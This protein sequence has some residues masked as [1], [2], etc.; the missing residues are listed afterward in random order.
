MAIEIGA[1]RA[2][3][4]LNSAAFEKGARRAEASMSGL[5]RSLQRASRRFAQIGRTM[6]TR[7]TL[8]LVGLGSVALKSSL[9]VVD[10]Q[11][12]MAQSLGTS[13]RSIQVLARAADRAGVSTGEL[14]QIALQLTKR[15]SQ[16]AGGTGP[17]VKALDRLGLS[18]DELIK[19]DLDQ[20][21]GTINAAI[22]ETVPAAEQAAVSAKLFGD[23]AGVLASLLDAS[24]IKAA[25]D[26]IERFGVA[27]TEVEADQIE[28]A[29]DAISALG[30]VTRGLA[31][32]LAVALAPSLQKL[33][34]FLADVAERFSGLPSEMQSVIGVATALGVALGPISIAIGAMVSGFAALASPI[35]IA[36]LGIGAVTAAIG[37]VVVKW[38]DWV[39]RFP[40]LGDGLAL[41]QDT[42]NKFAELV[43]VVLAGAMETAQAAFAS[44]Q[45]LL[46][47]DFR[48]A[49]EG[50][51]GVGDALVTGL[52]NAL[53]VLLP[54]AIRDAIGQAQAA[55]RDLIA[56]ILDAIRSVGGQ[57]LEAGRQLGRDLIDGLREGIEARVEAVKARIQGAANQITDFFKK[58]F[59]VRSP[60]RVFMEIGRNLIEGLS[61]GIG[62]SLGRVQ[63]Q[64]STAANSLTDVFSA[65]GFQTAAERVSGAVDE[66]STSLGD[67][68]VAGEN[69]GSALRGV[70]QRIASDLISSGIRQLVGGLFSGFGG[71]GG[72]G[73]FGGLL[74]F[75]G[76]GFTGFGSRSGGVDGR[77]GFPAILHPNETVIDHTAARSVAPRQAVQ[78]HQHWHI[79]ANG[80]ESVRQ[81]V[82]EEEPRITQTSLGA[83]QE[84]LNRG[85]IRGVT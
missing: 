7:L 5:Q 27:V 16:A 66:I 74:S 72:G 42:L 59:Q 62:G 43:G 80:D 8:P 40:A 55:V 47:G 78:I 50:L 57:I 11:S 22:R 6:T 37:L 64:A 23:R 19:L 83:F 68:I 51:L 31:N 56:A 76:G 49:L 71:G 14:D 84:A 38:D 44:L 17:A 65:S 10:A 15:L 35:G 9:S 75:D 53:N 30:L 70:F 81:I 41:L 3:L 45:A 73:L 4:S 33:A 60:S 82:R 12:K 32:Q 79:A 26:E 67:A 39:E 77:G 48:G 69:M 63:A 1:L 18:A 58:P 13:T 34:E 29:N 46:R 52:G 28:A 36:V 21:I 54:A 2:L 61:I 25:S 85:R 24:T 20:Q